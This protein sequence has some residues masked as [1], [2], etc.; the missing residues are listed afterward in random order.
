MLAGVTAD[1]VDQH[2]GTYD[3]AGRLV[4]CQK[5]V[6]N[7]FHVR[8]GGAVVRDGGVLG[9][10]YN[11]NAT[12]SIAPRTAGATAELT[13]EA[14]GKFALN[15]GQMY[16]GD[17]V[18]GGRSVLNID[19]KSVT[20]SVYE[21]S[22]AYGFGVGC[23]NGLGELNV[24]G[25]KLDVGNY[26]FF[27]GCLGYA[28]ADAE[29]RTT[30]CCPTGVVN[31]SRGDVRVYGYGWHYAA[32]PC[33]LLIGNGLFAPKRADVRSASRFR[34]E[35]NLTGGSL[36]T[37]VGATVVGGGP[38][39]GELNVAGGTFSQN[40]YNAFNELVSHC[41]LVIGMEG[42][43]GRMTVSAGSATVTYQTFVGGA[44]KKDL[45]HTS[46]NANYYPVVANA[47]TGTLAVVG[48]SFLCNG[49]SGHVIVGADG[50]GTLEI[51]GTG[52]FGC[53]D[54]VLSDN[55]ASVL[56]FDLPATRRDIAWSAACT[57]LVI[58]SG[59]KLTVDASKFT[60]VQVPL[61][62][63][64][65]VRGTVT[66]AFAPEQLEFICPPEQAKLFQDAEV[67]T[68]L[69][70]EKGLWIKGRPNGTLILFR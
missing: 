10:A 39:D 58:T 42:G 34:G 5:D 7:K 54:L 24:T 62:K 31:I 50:V 69:D 55:V 27:I 63:L 25:G 57:N 52:V 11:G 47:A 68:E 13:I 32:F 65:T 51:G 17:D 16:V 43:T 33:G 45:E 40:G 23:K 53:R 48:G 19:G 46:I 28:T 30:P 9:D 4:F 66:G 59:A 21:S 38:A 60:G 36:L 29:Y 1:Y 15:Q 64:L 35:L 14:G 20:T 2:G 8:D 70:G 37:S 67:L 49:T 56:R 6:G 44:L 61:T 12:L 41:P 18:C 3:I 22:N 26:G